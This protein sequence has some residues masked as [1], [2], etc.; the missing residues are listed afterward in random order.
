MSKKHRRQFSSFAPRPVEFDP[1]YSS[2][3]RDLRRIGLLAGSFILVL[4]VVAIFQD[5]LLAAFLK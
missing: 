2:T 4:V 3:R 1:D 5:Q